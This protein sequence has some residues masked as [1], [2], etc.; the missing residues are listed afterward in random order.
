MLVEWLQPLPTVLP[1]LLLPSLAPCL[2][3]SRLLAPLSPKC[4]YYII[5]VK[6]A[7]YINSGRFCDAGRG[8]ITGMQLSRITLAV[9]VTI[10]LA[11]LTTFAGEHRSLEVKHEFQR[12]HPC[13][14]TGRTTGLCPG[15][16]KDHIVPLACGGPDA[17]SNLQWQT[18]GDGKAKERWERRACQR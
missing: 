15:Y 16:I 14:P 3:P 1:S 17:V 6:C 9:A 2:V 11:P 18:I 7:R 4:V 5:S 13:P 10:A 8:I 12:L